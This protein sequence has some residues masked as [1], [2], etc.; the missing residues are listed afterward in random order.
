MNPILLPLI[1]PLV[2]AILIGL[3]RKTP[4]IRE[5]MSLSTATL[6]FL[7]VLPLFKQTQLGE[8][9]SLTLL[10]MMPGLSITFTV[11]PLGAIFA[12]LASFLWIITTIY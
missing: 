9:P 10:E 1:I 11:E 4:N 12:V 8:T 3:A 7:S 5:A 6:L 2:G